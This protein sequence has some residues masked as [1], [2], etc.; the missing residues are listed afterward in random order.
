MR[1]GFDAK[2]AVSNLTGI[3]NYS[4][5]CINSLAGSMQLFLF[6]SGKRKD[7]AVSQITENVT[8]MF[9][10]KF[11]RSGLLGELWRN[12]LV[13]FCISNSDIHIYHGLSNEL[14]LGIRHA[15]CKSVVTIHDL[16]FMRYPHTYSLSQRCILRLKTRYACKVAD[17]IIAISQQ[18]KRD[19]MEL[20]HIPEEKITVVY[21][22]V[23]TQH[24]SRKV[25]ERQIRSIKE[26][27]S[28]PQQYIICVG[29]IERRKNQLT[30]LKALPLLPEEIHLVLV[31]KESKHGRITYQK[32]I[33]NY[34]EE[35][36]L[37]HRLHILNHAD[38]SELPA[39]YQGA[40]VFACLSMY[41]GFG[42]PIVEALLSRVPVIAA[43]GSCLEEAGGPHSTYIPAYSQTQLASAV[44]RIIQNP[45]LHKEMTVNGW[46]YAQQFT[47]EHLA[48]NLQRIYNE[49][50]HSN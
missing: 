16:I 6:S 42:I 19:L 30:L 34:A 13:C 7:C 32:E 50:Y 8:W 36:R 17:K 31:G 39:L 21:Q 29:T 2:K 38:N 26:R 18:T 24:F 11:F 27:Y 43:E 9:P 10:P 25:P 37:S 33:E 4:R 45:S 48:T 28:L 12:A 3:G 15:G 23:D 47:D 46:K 14:P 40:T 1:I 20:Y 49:L 44:K 41:E 5:R 22:S 35:K